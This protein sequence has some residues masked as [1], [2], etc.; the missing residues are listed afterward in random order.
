MSVKM[1]N[2][3]T[4]YEVHTANRLKEIIQFPPNAPPILPDKILIRLWTLEQ[5]FSYGDIQKYTELCF[6]SASRMQFL[7]VKICSANFFF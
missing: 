2:C 6:P 7:S 5:K 3:K 4:F 1:K